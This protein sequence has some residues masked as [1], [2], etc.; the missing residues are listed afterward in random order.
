MLAAAQRAPSSSN[1]QACS[2]IVIRNA[3]TKARL[4]AL[5]GNQQHIIDC[6]VFFALCADL[7][8]AAHACDLHGTQ[9]QKQTLENA[10]VASVDVALVGMSLSLAADSLGLGSLMIG[11][12]RNH[13]LEVA[14]LLKLPPMSY[15]VF[16]LCVG[17][18]KK[19]PRAKPRQPLSAFIHHETYD[20]SN[21]SSA[22]E[23]YD[24][25]LHAFYNSQ[26]RQ[27]P[28]R[29]W[30]RTVADKFSVPNRKHLRQ[31]LNQLGFELE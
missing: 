8:G 9:F 23:Q 27:T 17:W 6:P 25:E 14:A 19:A 26:G 3:E 2:I 31:Q 30:T 22:L 11:G 16:G 1:I 15:V 10:L 13:P 7:N 4:A 28:E 18:P 5:A 29:S 20:A 21:R 12:M 24:R